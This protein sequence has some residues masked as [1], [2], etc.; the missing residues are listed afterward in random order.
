MADATNNSDAGSTDGETGDIVLPANTFDPTIDAGLYLF[1]SIGDTVYRDDDGNGVQN[2]TEPGIGGVRVILDDA[3]L[4]GVFGTA[5]DTL[6]LADAPTNANGQYLFSN[7]R[8]G[9]YRVRV[10]ATTLP[11]GLAQTVDLDGLATAN[12]ATAPIASGQARRDVDFGYRGTA[13]LGDTVWYDLDRSGTQNNGEPGIGNVVITLTEAGADGQFGTPDDVTIGTQTTDAQG[14]YLF[15]NLP[16]GNYRAAVDVGTLPG[17]LAATFDL[18]SGLANPDSVAVATLAGGEQRLDVDFGYR[19]TGSIGDRV[20]FD[21][22]G[23]GTQDPGEPGLPGVP[24]TLTWAGPDG[25]LGTPDDLTRTATTGANGIYLF[26]DLPAGV[27]TVTVTPTPGLTQTG[28]PDATL[29]SMSTVTLTAGQNNDTQDFG[30]QGQSSLGGTVFVDVNTNG[31]REPGETRIPGVVVTLSGT[32][33]AG[34]MVTRTATT[35]TDGTYLFV[36]LAPGTYSV[37]ETQPAAYA[38]GQDILGS[39]GGTPSGTVGNDRFTAI[40]L[41]PGGSGVNY[42]FGEIGGLVSGTVFLDRDRDGTRTPGE[43]AIPGVIVTIR[44]GTGTVVGTAT[45]GPDGSYSFPGLPAGDYTITETQPTGYGDTPTGPFMPNTRPVTLPPGVSVVNQNFGDTLG[46]VSGTVYADVNNNGTQNPSEPGIPGVVLTLI[47]GTGTPVATATTDANGN[48]SFTD[49]PAGSYTIVETQPAGYANGATTAGPTGGTATSGTRI[50]TVPLAPGGVAPSNVFGEVGTGSVTGTVF[51]DINKDGTPQPGEPGIPGVVV[52]LTGPDGTVIA[53]T[54][55]GPDGNYRFDN[56]TPGTYGVVELQPAG[57]GSTANTGGDT[58]SVTVANGQSAAVI[59]FPDTLGSIAGTV[60]SDIDLS[61]TLSPNDSLLNGITLQLLDAAGNVVAT[62]TTDLNGRYR[63]DNLRAGNYTVVEVQPPLPTSLTAGYYD[64]ADTPGTLGG[65]SPAKNRITVA[66]PGGG[67]GINY[68][69]GEFQPASTFGFVYV[70]ANRNGVRDA[71][72][73]PIPGVAVTVSGTAFAGTPFARPLVASDLPGGSLTVLTDANG[74]WEFGL[75]PPGSYRFTEAQPAGFLDGQERDGDPVGPPAAVGNDLFD[76]VALR[77]VQ[78][79]GPF[80]FGEVL[81]PPVPPFVPLTPPGPLTPID[82]FPPARPA[83]VDP[84]KRQF[85]GSTTMSGATLPAAPTLPTAPNFQLRATEPTF[86]AMGEDLGGGL[87]RVFDYQSG[88]ERYRF[89]PYPGFT[90]GVH[91]ATG[92]VTGDGVPDIVTTPGVGGGPIVRVFDGRTGQL[93]REVMAF[94][95]SFRGGLQLTV[96]DINGDGLA[97]VIVAPDAGGG[98]IVRAFDGQTFTQIANFFALDETFRGG[99]RI[100]ASDLNADGLADLVVTAG[101]GGGPRVAGYDGATLTSA[102]PSRLFGDFFA[103]APELRSGFFV[104]AA[105]VDGDG[106]SDIVLGA[107]PGGG[108]RAATYSG[109][110]LTQSNTPA[111]MGDIFAGDPNSRSGVRVQ[112]IDLNGDGLAELVAAPG[113]G[114]R[115]VVRVMDPRTGAM[116]DQ[117]YAFPIDFLGGVTV[118]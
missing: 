33:S 88:V 86:V 69:F 8:P 5:D 52:Q 75:L 64:G 10:D 114:D 82:F 109:R 66:L 102:N 113:T 105:D 100:A 46:T 26:P 39:V 50:T 83:P 41:T 55:T 68:D 57:L 32:D 94:E 78:V 54:T 112:A 61:G 16:A 92:D 1:A 107:G 98:P 77:P 106:F 2:G 95:E 27:Y 76:G 29:D 45:T 111:V 70:D 101:V 24:V 43:P 42:D 59:P 63:F 30:Y 73:T 38:D 34:N 48:Y 3:G 91:V 18:D 6:D 20:W 35:G 11:A 15:A 85:L 96:G 25:Q 62:T 116:Y 79:R 99:L 115:P 81:T 74:R 21:T 117:F 12:E 9:T 53:T 40:T 58:R 60:Y 37:S 118:G 93:V 87:V 31:V 22:N 19:G 72:E 108:P 49:L 17:G 103:F 47:D 71:G 97:D 44:D 90:G 7:L 84:T 4:D 28:D 110:A 13:S 51:T 14:K 65:T 89:T 80:D 67:D 36:N 104:T 23:D 56:L